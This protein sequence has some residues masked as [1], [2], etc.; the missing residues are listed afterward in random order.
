M[1]M[2][3]RRSGWSRAAAAARSA[4][5]SGGAAF[6]LGQLV[7]EAD[8]GLPVKLRSLGDRGLYARCRFPQQLLEQLALFEELVVER[9]VGDA[10]F[11]AE[12]WPYP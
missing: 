10:Q 1:A 5:T 4:V 8:A 11:G 2:M 7:E 3:R 6:D 9:R 12:Y